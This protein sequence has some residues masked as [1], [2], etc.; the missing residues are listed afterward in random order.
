MRGETPAQTTLLAD[1]TAGRDPTIVHTANQL[2]YQQQ[3]QHRPSGAPTPASQPHIPTTPITSAPTPTSMPLPT[4]PAYRPLI[5]PQ[6]IH[7]NPVW[8]GILSHDYVPVPADNETR[9]A[10]SES[11]HRLPP[12]RQHHL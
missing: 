2:M 4:E 8:Q 12:T 1:L 5:T 3:Q 9:R 6:N 10:T 11:A 7:V